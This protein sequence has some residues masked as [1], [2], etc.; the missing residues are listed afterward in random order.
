MIDEIESPMSSCSLALQDSRVFE[1][2]NFLHNGSP[3]STSVTGRCVES[4]TA[5]QNHYFRLLRLS[6]RIHGGNAV[7]RASI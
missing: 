2:I 6:Q 1:I 7:T 4:R 5:L 3:V